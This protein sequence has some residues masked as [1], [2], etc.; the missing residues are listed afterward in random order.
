MYCKSIYALLHP[1]EEF[2]KLIH[3]YYMLNDQDPVFPNLFQSCL[4]R[5]GLDE[6]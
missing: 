6:L 3:R 4:I 2:P 5:L 1:G